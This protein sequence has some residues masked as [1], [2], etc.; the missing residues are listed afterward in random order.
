MYKIVYPGFWFTGSCVAGDIFLEGIVYIECSLCPLFA[1]NDRYVHCLYWMIAMSIVYIDWSL[2]Y[3]HCLHWLNVMST[4]YIDW[5][6][7]PLFTL[8]D[9]YVHCLHWLIVMSTVYIGWSLCPLFALNDR[10]VHSLHWLIV[11]PIVYID[12]SL[13]PLW[14]RYMIIMFLLTRASSAKTEWFNVVI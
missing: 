8:T 5:S 10:Y 14:W 1:L 3:V 12:W 4:V 11:M 6:L 2:C 13:C 7:C 9:R